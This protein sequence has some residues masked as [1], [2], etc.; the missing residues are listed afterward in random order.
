VS[1]RFGTL[2]P[3]RELAISGAADPAELLRIARQL[4]D[5]VD[6]LWIGESVLARPRMDAY[7]LL[8]AV[9]G[10]TSRAMLG[11]AVLLPSLRNPIAFAHAIATIDALSAGRLV[12]GVGSGFPQPDTES[13]FASLGAD[14]RRRV[15]GV[16]A[17]IDAARAIWRASA[18]GQRASDPTNRFGFAGVAVTP[19]PHRI[20]GPRTWLATASPAGLARCGTYHDGWLPYTPSPEE[21]RDGLDRVRAAA[22]E[23]GRAPSTITPGLYVTVAVGEG[24]DP[25]ARLDAYCR[26]YYG[27]PADVMGDL[28]ALIAG[29]VGAVVERLGQYVEAGA[30]HI[31]IRHATLDVRGV[32]AQATLLYESLRAARPA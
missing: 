29:P 18:S 9:S 3:T 16:E 26:A 31:V 21:Y 22:E 11:T 25:H 13:E 23:A 14:Y 8:A 12:L 4:D 24:S 32:G 28:Q 10:C 7:A 20:G 6:S 17:T 5:V 19:P 15:S 1:P 27:H 2:L 30:E